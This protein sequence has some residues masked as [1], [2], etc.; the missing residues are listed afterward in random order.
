MFRQPEYYV[1][2]GIINIGLSQEAI[3]NENIK[4]FDS[5]VQMPRY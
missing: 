4:H 5:S 1:Y 2:L 3:W